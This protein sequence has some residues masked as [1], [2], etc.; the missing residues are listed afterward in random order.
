MHARG[1]DFFSNDREWGSIEFV[2]T[3]GVSAIDIDVGAARNA[4]ERRA[5]GLL[6]PGETEQSRFDCSGAPLVYLRHRVVV[7]RHRTARGRF[8]EHPPARPAM[9]VAI[10][11]VAVMLLF[12]GRGTYVLP[13]MW[14]GEWH[15]VHM[16]PDHVP[17]VWIWGKPLWQGWLRLAPVS[18][19]VG[20][21]V[22]V[23]MAFVLL[24]GDAQTGRFYDIAGIIGLAATPFMVMGVT[25]V[26]FNRPK[27][28]VVPNMRHQRGAV[29]QWLSRGQ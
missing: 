7:G 11:A 2:R 26:F 18:V 29:A 27:F 13:Q 20:W 6:H 24:A 21:L 23:M 8:A 3:T 19:V 14:R 15:Y 17:P 5:P 9:T 22:I 16:D 1:R 10:L 12:V 28:M 25:V 4:A